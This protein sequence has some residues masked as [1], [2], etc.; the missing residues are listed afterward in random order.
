[1]AADQAEPQSASVSPPPSI[2]N[3]PFTGH[4]D[5]SFTLQMIMELKGSVGE[6]K[7]SIS[8]LKESVDKSCER[9]ERQVDRI[10]SRIE[11]A[12]GKI[13]S[14]GTTLKIAGVLLTVALVVG[15]FFINTAKDILLARLATD[16]NAQ[17]STQTAAPGA[18][19]SEKYQKPK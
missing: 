18:P 6:L 12:E 3:P 17:P 8:A 11:G 9:I 16:S 5:H 13:S 14:H 10:D 15:G 7:S 19:Q 4:H 1:M 2:T